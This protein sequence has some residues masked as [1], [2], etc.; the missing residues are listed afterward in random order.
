VEENRPNPDELLSRLKD[1]EKR[2]EHGKLT[3]FFGACPGVGKT[4]A[5]LQAAGREL[6]AGHDVVAGVVETHGRSETAAMM[7]GLESIPRRRV[8]YHGIVLEEFDLDAALKRRPSLILVD[9]LA[10]TNAEGSRHSKRWLDVGELLDA[11]IDVYTTLNVQ[12]LESL[13][14]L[15]AQITGVVV[16]ETIPDSIVEHAD[17]VKLIDLPPDE[18]LARLAEGKVYIHAQA[19]YAAE[20]FFKKGNLIGLRELALRWTAE[21]VDAQMQRWRRDAGI[22]RTWSASDR[23]MVCFSHSPHSPRVIRAAGRMAKGLRATLTAVH[24]ERPSAEMLSGEDRVQLARNFHLAEKLGAEVVTLASDDPAREILSFARK[25]NITKIVIGKPGLRNLKERLFGSFVDHIIKASGDIDVFVTRG[26]V[27]EDGH[28]RP[29]VQGRKRRI[30]GYIAAAMVVAAATTA[31]SVLFGASNLIDSVM[32]YILGIVSVSLWYGLAPSVAAAALSVIAF[33]Y[34]FVQPYFSFAVADLKYVPTFF[35]MFVVAVV[36]SVLTERVRRQA[37]SSRDRER[38]TALMYSM[39]R[40]LAKTASRESVCE[41][42][43]RRVG[44]IFESDVC[45]YSPPAEGDAI[46]RWPAKE[47]D[48]AGAEAGI[49]SW[50]LANGREAGLGTETLPGAAGLYLPLAGPRDRVGVMGVIP[51][52]K[53][54]FDDP[55]QRHLLDALAMQA[56]MA[57]E[58]VEYAR[59]MEEERLKAEKERLRNILLSSVS[60]DLRTPIAAIVGASSTLLQSSPGLDEKAN[61]ELLESIWDEA[62]RLNRFVRNLLDMTRLEAGVVSVKKELQPV[63]EVVGAA[64]T[65]LEKILKGREIVTSI[66]EDLPLVPIDAVL[67]E[68]LLVNLLE[69]AVKYTPSGSPITVV[70][71]VE[72]TGVV[73]EV[74]DRGPGIPKGD[75]GHIFEKFYRSKQAGMPSGVGLGL[76]ICK[77]VAEVHGGSIKAGNRDG[78]GTVISVT[79][80]LE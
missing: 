74:L 60:H 77:A 56:A 1:E 64:L 11:G 41:V 72:G 6:I 75:S 15:I 78:G 7:G 29:Q 46:I 44:E 31:N 53:K 40:E 4:Y 28:E 63:E 24:V 16:H 43:A 30:A 17:E 68:Q 26:D 8:E 23:I 61:R 35:V 48:D 59:R 67:M 21:R 18:L 52:D 71:G 50:V 19:G 36:I 39:S 58:R 47:G 37:E 14:D 22:E 20:N 66:P 12:H 57:L 10:H 76:A 80:P 51:G 5:M 79:I 25:A 49:A 62:D 42:T 73:L 65:R 69:N 27:V 55:E 9:E 33:D 2:A 3:V 32:I 34:F 38:R 13:N 54:R 70:A 45:F